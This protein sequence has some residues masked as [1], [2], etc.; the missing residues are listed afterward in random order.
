MG[1]IWGKIGT[2]Q[3]KKTKIFGH[4]VFVSGKDKWREILK[5]VNLVSQ[6]FR[7]F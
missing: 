3:R 4:G 2:L 1:G 6:L 5:F 7:N